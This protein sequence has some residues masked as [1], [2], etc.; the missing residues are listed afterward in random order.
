MCSLAPHSVPQTPPH[1]RP[2]PVHH[3]QRMIV[4]RLLSLPPPPAAEMRAQHDDDHTGVGRIIIMPTCVI[5]K[6]QVGQWGALAMLHEST[7][8]L[9]NKPC[10]AACSALLHSPAVSHRFSALVHLCAKIQNLVSSS[11]EVAWTPLTCCEASALASARQGWAVGQYMRCRS[12]KD[13]LRARRFPKE[14]WLHA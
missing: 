4:D 7:V 3:C 5:N 9:Q 6:D 10:A 8:H 12:V 13:K 1:Y 2:R 11:T 14:G